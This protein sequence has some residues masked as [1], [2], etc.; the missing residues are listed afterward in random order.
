MPDTKTPPKFTPKSTLTREQWLKMG[1]EN[2]T[3]LFKAAGYEVPVKIRASVGWPSKGG[4]GKK[5]KV[6]GQ[7]WDTSCSADKTSEIFISPYLKDA[8]QVLAVLIHEMVHAIVGVEHGHKKPFITCAKK[9]G[10]EGK[11]TETTASKELTEKL[12]GI[13]KRLGTY[14]HAKLDGRANSGPPKQGSR[15]LKCECGNESCGMVIRTT[16]KWLDEVGLPTCQCGSEFTTEH[17]DTDGADDG[18]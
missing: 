12:V 7:C 9:V 13:S 11:M 5:K 3:R 14:P 8:T 18:E 1:I 17:D 6:I 15:M 2:V 16:A 10:L 4:L